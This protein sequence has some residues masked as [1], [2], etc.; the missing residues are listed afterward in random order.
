MKVVI[1]AGGYGTR[2][3]EETSLIPKPMVQIGGKP[4]LWHIMKFYESQGFNDFIICCGYKG[5]VI[6]DYFVNYNM[7]ESDVQINTKSGV[8]S[9]Y[10]K[11]NE[12]WNVTLVNTGIDSFTGERL[13]KIKPYIKDDT[14]MLTYGDGLSD[15]NLQSLLNYHRSHKSI[16]TCTAIRK[17]SRFGIIHIDDKNNQILQF[18]EKPTDED[19]WINGGF[20]VLNKDIF[21]YINNDMLERSLFPKLAKNNQLYAYK[22]TGFWKAMDTLRDKHEL[23]HFWN[24]NQAKWKIWNE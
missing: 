20:F 1:L 7:Y 6:K 11:C 19:S 10:K 2:L 12:N 16:A 18:D 23:E 17:D 22:H 4:I 13:Q 5:E 9:V 21:Y 3:Q 15:V 24:T 8:C 14:F